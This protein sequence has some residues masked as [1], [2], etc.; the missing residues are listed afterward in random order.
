MF[1]VWGYQPAN[2]NH[3][4]KCTLALADIMLRPRIYLYL[5]NKI[6]ILSQ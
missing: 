4:G 1:Y 6:I 2:D 5:I 3:G